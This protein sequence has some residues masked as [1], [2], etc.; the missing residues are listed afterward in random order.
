MGC[1]FPLVSFHLNNFPSRSWGLCLPFIL[2]I[3]FWQQHVKNRVEGLFVCASCTGFPQKPHG[4]TCSHRE[5]KLES[6][7]C[8]A[9]LAC[10]RRPAG[11]EQTCPLHLLP[12]EQNRG[13]LVGWPTFPAPGGSVGCLTTAHGGPSGTELMA[14]QPQLLKCPR[15]EGS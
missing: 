12:R 3:E 5:W 10:G 6:S 11:S 9:G 15:P 14:L 1:S 8:L 4:G 7:A 2:R 13:W